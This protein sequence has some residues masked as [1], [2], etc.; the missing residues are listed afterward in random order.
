MQLELNMS[1]IWCITCNEVKTLV[2]STEILL[3]GIELAEELILCPDC[4]NI[5]GEITIG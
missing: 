3:L 2:I 1:K 5:I 4:E